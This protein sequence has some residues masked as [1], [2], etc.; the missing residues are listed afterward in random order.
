VIF[1]AYEIVLRRREADTATWKG[2][3]GDRGSTR[4]ILAAYATT[5]VINVVFAGSAVGDVGA[6]WCW[7]GVA[8]MVFG[9]LLRAWAMSTLGS[10]Y[11]RTLRT[12]D[13]QHVI[14]RGPYRLVRHPGYSGS[15]MIWVG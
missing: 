15:L 8:V 2:D 11:T 1:A 9:L 10:Y 5:V 13:H 3:S 12:V 6:G 7:V 14:D 4:L